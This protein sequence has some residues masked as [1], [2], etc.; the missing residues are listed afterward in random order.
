M[1]TGNAGGIDILIDGKA[2]PQLGPVGEIRT[3]IVLDA[4]SLLDG[5]IARP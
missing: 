5:R 3:N 2:I 4:Q 1:T